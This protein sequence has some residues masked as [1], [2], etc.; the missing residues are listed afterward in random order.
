MKLT[1]LNTLQPER[2][3]AELERCCGAAA[4]VEAMLAARPFADRAALHAAAE[5][6]ARALSRADWLEAFAHHPRIGDVAALRAKFAAT[7]AWAGAEQGGAV[8]APEA[9]LAALAR[10]NRA[11]EERFGYIFIVCATGQRAD[12]MLAIL[13]SR[14][15]NDPARELDIAA[16]EQRRITRLRLEKLVEEP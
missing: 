7:A 16:A 3:R 6:A 5:R 2:A 11:Y 1:E 8:G 9:V 12:E 13:E 14:L 10:G 4:W 15:A